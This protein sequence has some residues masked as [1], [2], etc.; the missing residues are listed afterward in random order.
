MQLKPDPLYG[1]RPKDDGNLIW[2]GEVWQLTQVLLGS[3][4]DA[5]IEG[6]LGLQSVLHEMSLLPA[7]A[8]C[9]TNLG[10]RARNKTVAIH[11]AASN[12]ASPFQK[13]RGS[14]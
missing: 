1:R 14:L 5:L 12:A 13:R 6:L 2:N 10:Y 4:A 8:K 9:R 11:P 3:S 7:V